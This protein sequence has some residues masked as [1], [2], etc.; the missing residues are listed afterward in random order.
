M[1]LTKNTT[2]AF[3]A[4]LATFCLYKVSMFFVYGGIVLLVLFLIAFLIDLAS[5]FNKNVRFECERICPPRM[6]NGDKNVITLRIKSLCKRDVE[7][8]IIDEVPAEFQL[9][10]F[11]LSCRLNRGE[12]KDITYTLLPTKRGEYQ[13]HDVNIYA[14]SRLRLVERR[15]KFDCAMTSK[16]YPSYAII[17]NAQLLSPSN[18]SREL[19][20]K[21]IR[22]TGQN[23]EF[24][25]IK[26]YDQG[27]DYRTIN[28]KA[29]ARRHQLMSNSYGSTQSQQIYNIID[30]GKGMQQ[31]FKGMTMLDY[32][33]N[34]AIALS[35][36][37]IENNDNAGLITFEKSVA[38]HIPAGKERHQRKKILDALYN[39]TTDF[40]HSDMSALYEYASRH[41]TKRS[42]FIL[43]TT[44]N[45]MA[46][47]EQEL[48]YLKMI[49]KRH[50][51]LVVF[52]KDSELEEMCRKKPEQE[53]DYFKQTIGEKFLFEQ[54]L[55]TKRL[56]Q[57]GIHALLTR[58]E[59]LSVN[60]INKYVEMKER[61]AI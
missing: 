58:P 37:A 6:S 3:L 13:F 23:Q 21:S 34:A 8:E 20:L 42:L 19:G 29:S 27:D 9:R 18:Q 61:R 54:K 24:E 44:F 1:Y 10:D 46:S 60:T 53:A 57:N 48:P 51:L 49:A 55:I 26:T 15:F 40:K 32:A 39:E 30:K 38:T 22:R 35:F 31:A 56:Q 17:H 5:V 2:I 36:V 14:P 28:W 4:I 45:S 33:I 43:Y 11:R 47:M 16:V 50:T 52:F 59:H 7:I 25:N 41:I 12:A